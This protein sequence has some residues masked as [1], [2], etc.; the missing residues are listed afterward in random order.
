MVGNAHLLGGS[1]SHIFE[2]ITGNTLIMKY[3]NF[4]LQLQI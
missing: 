2:I 3:E 4:L 1:S